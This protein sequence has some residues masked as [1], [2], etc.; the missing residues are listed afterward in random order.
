MSIKILNEKKLNF[1]LKKL[2]DNKENEKAQ[3]K[4]KYKNQS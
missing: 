3:G 4:N 1:Q 2:E